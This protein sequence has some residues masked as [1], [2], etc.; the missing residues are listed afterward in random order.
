[1]LPVKSVKHSVVKCLVLTFSILISAFAF[2]QDPDYI[3]GYGCVRNADGSL[4]KEKSILEAKLSLYRHALEEAQQ[5]VSTHTKVRNING[6]QDYKSVTAVDSGIRLPKEDIEVIHADGYWVA[7]ILRSKVFSQEVKWVEQNITINNTVHSHSSYSRG[8]RRNESFTRTVRR[9][10][11]IG[12]SGV[13][14]K[15][16][17][18]RTTDTRV[19][20]NWN[21]RSGYTRTTRVE[22]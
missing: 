7:R 13:A 8:Y 15:T 16:I 6:K 17:P 10:D 21:G 22:Y 3:Y 9:T 1:M 2:A 14:V 4:N 19:R 11:I 5:Q 12:P 20:R 18:G